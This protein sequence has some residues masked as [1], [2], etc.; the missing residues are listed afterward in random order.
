MVNSSARNC[1]Y[2]FQELYTIS[3][4]NQCQDL[5]FDIKEDRRIVPQGMGSGLFCWRLADPD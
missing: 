5:I 1:L 2:G 4:G 3:Q